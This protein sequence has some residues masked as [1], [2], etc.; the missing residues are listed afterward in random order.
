MKEREIW[1][2]ALA[3]IHLMVSK[4]NFATWF[5]DT[6]ISY[7]KDGKA[8]ISVPNNFVKEWLKQKYQKTILKILKSLDPEIREIDFCVGT[9]EKESLEK[10]FSKIT[11]KGSLFDINQKTNLNS[12][13]TFSNFVVGSFNE[14]AFAAAQA[15]VE[16][17]GKVYNPLFVYG[18]VG[19]G[20]T[21][22]LQATGNEI[23][24]KYKDLEIRYFQVNTLISEIINSIKNRKIEEFKKSFQEIDVLILDDV[25]FLAGKEKTQEEFFFIFNSLYEKG[26]QII[27]SSD[28]PPKAIPSLEERLRSRFEGGMIAD[29]SLPD[30]ETRMAILK[31]KIKERGISISDEILNY[32][33]TNV[34]NN[35]REMEGALNVLTTFVKMQ[36]KE[37][38]LKTAKSL[39]RNFISPLP[40]VSNIKKVIKVISEF[41]G[42]EEKEIVSH[43]R[44][45]EI[46]KPR[47]IAMYILRED[48]K[49]SFPTIARRLGGKDHT[50]AIHAVEKIKKEMEK[51]DELKEEIKVIRERIFV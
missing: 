33:A 42:I 9:L 44:K 28:R 1:E 37:L 43:S 29:I 14:L 25:Q 21:H 35:I 38:N 18:G 20:K 48:F 27:I 2:S 7:L 46:V 32:I 26:K 11:W 47:Q 13:Y 24:K 31:V 40:K 51:N 23:L 45:W 15:I 4:A 30:F 17:P 49:Y 50:T 6:K 12:R 16:N 5:K 8:V 19:L 10:I 41:Y 36:Q 39:L 34:K 22:L 3:Q